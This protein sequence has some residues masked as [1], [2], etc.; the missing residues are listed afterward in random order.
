MRVRR[1][2]GTHGACCRVAGHVKL[3]RA[4]GAAA[5]SD[6]HQ[7]VETLGGDPALQLLVD[8]ERGSQGTIA[9]A[10]DRL[11]RHRP[12]GSGAVKIDPEAAFGMP[13]ERRGPHRLARFGAAQVHDVPAAALGAEIVIESDHAVDLGPRQVELLGDQADRVRRHEPDGLLNG[14][15]NGEQ[16]PGLVLPVG[17]RAQHRRLFLFAQ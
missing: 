4:H 7:L 13:L 12:V 10:I 2:I 9:E 16:S 14:V 15:Q 6:S 3:E 17:A 8:H 5:R 11:Q 1:G